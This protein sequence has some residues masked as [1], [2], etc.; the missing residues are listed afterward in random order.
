[1]S[2]NGP[3][4]SMVEQKRL[5]LNKVVALKR[6]K[7]WAAATAA[8]T[9]TGALVGSVVPGAGTV[10]GAVVGF[11]T[12]SGAVTTYDWIDAYEERK[13]THPHE[14]RLERI[15]VAMMMMEEEEG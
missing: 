5:R 2:G 12:S 3:A 8:G 10:I 6:A 4:P 14:T 1:M 11:I 7:R 15:S 9:A 13:K